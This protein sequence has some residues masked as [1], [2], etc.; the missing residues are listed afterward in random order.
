MKFGNLVVPKDT[1]IIILVFKIQR[2]KRYWG[3][4]ADVFNTPIGVSK[5]AKHPNALL[6]FRAGPRACI[7]QTDFCNA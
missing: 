3:E 6:A 2:S 1:W 5:A 7:S 4:D